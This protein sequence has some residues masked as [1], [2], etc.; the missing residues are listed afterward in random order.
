MQTSLLTSMKNNREL[1][2]YGFK[3]SMNILQHNISHGKQIGDGIKNKNLDD[4]LG[5]KNRLEQNYAN[6]SLAVVNSRIRF[7]YKDLYVQMKKLSSKMS[8]Y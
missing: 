3:Q 8:E 5:F 7:N 4:M 6:N 1:P 2:L